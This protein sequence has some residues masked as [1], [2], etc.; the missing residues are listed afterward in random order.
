MKQ[1]KLRIGRPKNFARI[2]YAA[3][4]ATGHQLY[5]RVRVR[6]AQK[7]VH[8]SG[9]LFDA[10]KG[11]PGAIIGCHLSHCA[12]R[13]AEAFPHPCLLPVFTRSTALIV[14]KIKRGKPVEAVR[15]RHSYA[16]IV[17]LNDTDITKNYVRE[18]PEITERTFLLSPP[19]SR[20]P[21][22]RRPAARRLKQGASRRD[23]GGPRPGVPKG[24]LSRATNAGLVNKGLLRLFAHADA[25]MMA[26]L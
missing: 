3:N 5:W 10:I 23:V 22:A 6:D 25:E 7:P 14:S 9:R 8:V 17:D 2:P 18:H 1:K 4:P 13:N 26:S 19:Q 12:L 16:E 21:G 15:Y 24:A 20:S 11:E